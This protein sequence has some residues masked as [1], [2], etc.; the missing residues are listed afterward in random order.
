MTPIGRSSPLAT[1]SGA[2]AVPVVPSS[3]VPVGEPSDAKPIELGPPFFGRFD[4]AAE[5]KIRAFDRFSANVSFYPEFLSLGARQCSR[6][7]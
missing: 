7:E 1:A 2:G 5:D 6:W 4:L 3:G